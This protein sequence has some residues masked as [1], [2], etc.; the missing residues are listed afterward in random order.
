MRIPEI[1]VF[2]REDFAKRSRLLEAVEA[3]CGVRFTCEREIGDPRL[4]GA[5]S[6]ASTR[7]EAMASARAGIRHLGFLAGA[8]VPSPHMEVR[9]GDVASVASIFR[10]STMPAGGISSVACAALDAGDEI[11]AEMGGRPLWIRR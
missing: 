4:D 3:V 7:V 5:V 9:F 8:R 10:A 11:V 6:F 1:A 2:P